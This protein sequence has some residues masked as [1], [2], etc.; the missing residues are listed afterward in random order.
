MTAKKPK[1]KKP[2]GRGRGAPS[3]Y[4]KAVAQRICDELAKGVPLLT[5]CKIPGMP[6]YATVRKW[7]QEKPDFIALSTRAREIGCHAMA[8]E[9]VEIA[10]DSRN[11]YQATHDAEGD[12]SGSR[13]NSEHVQRARLRIDTRMRLIGKWLPKVYG[14]KQQ[15]ELSGQVDLAAGLLA[16]RKRSGIG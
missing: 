1:A 5:I 16:A 14:E 11:D 10:D 6:K 9:C 12:E 3:I 4:S 2:T 15:V 8:D 13:F 7:E